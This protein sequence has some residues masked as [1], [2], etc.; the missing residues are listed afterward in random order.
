VRSRLRNARIPAARPLATASG[1]AVVAALW[2]TPPV[3]AGD[4]G[5]PEGFRVAETI[6]VGPSV[7]GFAELPDGRILTVGHT[8]KQLELIVEGVRQE[9]PLF[10][11]PNVMTSSEQG[12]LGIAIDPDFPDESWVYLFYTH[13]DSTNRVSRFPLAGELTDGSSA[14][15]EILPAEQV[16]WTGPSTLRFH[17]GGTLRFGSDKTLYISHGDDASSRGNVQ[18]LAKRHGKI[19]RINRDGSIPED[20]PVFP[21][22]PEGML[23]EIYAFGLRNPFRFCIDPMTDEILI[24]DVGGNQVEEL[25]LCRGG[26]NFGYPF[27]EGSE[28]FRDKTVLIPPEPTFPIAEYSHGASTYAIIALACYRPPKTPG[29]ADFPEPYHGTW[30][31]SDFFWPT[32]WN[33]RPDGAGGWMSVEFMTGLYQPAD[34]ALARAGGIFFLSYGQKI[35]RIVHDDIVPVLFPAFEAVVEAGAVR[36]TWRASEPAERFDVLRSSDGESFEPVGAVPAGSE[37]GGRHVFV[38]ATVPDG[39]TDAYYRIRA[40]GRDGTTTSSPTIRVSLL[41]VPASVVLHQNEPNPFGAST[42]IRFGVPETTSDAEVRL[43]VFDVGGRLVRVLLDARALPGREAVRWDGRDHDGRV[44]PSGVYY[45]RLSVA[46]QATTR[47]L[48]IQ[49]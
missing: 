35:V 9:P 24:G 40:H 33:L 38:D 45:Y 1:L 25:S 12:L 23:E 21:E 13:M 27:Y 6:D 32:I 37:A 8:S 44:V 4:Y 30:F 22:E 31:W 28:I 36:L 47:R 17:N 34:A 48:V 46:G 14:D 15:L 19:L 10:T 42:T 11:V 29:P 18:N 16:L 2:G 41:V 3:L 43:D 5:L 39:L 26:E 49:R 20:N 7:V